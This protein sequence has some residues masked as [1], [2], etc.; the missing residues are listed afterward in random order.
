MAENLEKRTDKDLAGNS[1]TEVYSMTGNASHLENP[2]DGPYSSNKIESPAQTHNQ[3]KKSILAWRVTLGVLIIAIAIGVFYFVGKGVNAAIHKVSGTAQA[4]SPII[5]PILKSNAD[6]FS[7]HPTEP[8]V[9]SYNIVP[10]G[11]GATSSTTPNYSGGMSNVNSNGQVLGASISSNNCPDYLG[12]QYYY[13][14]WTSPY[15]FRPYK[16]KAEYDADIQSRAQHP[17]ASQNLSLSTPAYTPSYPGYTPPT[18]SAPSYVPSS[19][20]PN[21]MV[22]S[23]TTAGKVVN[24]CPD[25]AAS[26]YDYC[27]WESPYIWRGIKNGQ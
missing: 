9:S 20:N 21:L 5:S 27:V 16:T 15:I 23:T 26:Q 4:Q 17:A 6:P 22:P 24:N 14:E 18:Y 1:E 25:Y 8:V 2:E 11:T 3:Q 19:Y 13:C 10:V 7:S 12:N